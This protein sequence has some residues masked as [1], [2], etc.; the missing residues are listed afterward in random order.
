MLSRF[1]PRVNTFT[2]ILSLYIRDVLFDESDAPEYP[3]RG[4]FVTQ[5][6]IKVGR[7]F[8]ID[9]DEDGR[10]LIT[11]TEDWNEMDEIQMFNI[12][13]QT[14]RKRLFRLVKVTEK[15]NYE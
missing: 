13:N 15:D 14:L 4:I 5:A 2:R 9:C 3:V 10:I 8:S 11:V 6:P 12:V 1:H 7:Y